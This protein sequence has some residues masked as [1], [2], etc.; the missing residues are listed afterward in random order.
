MVVFG[1]TVVVAPVLAVVAIQYLQVVVREPRVPGPGELASRLLLD[2]GDVS[3]SGSLPGG[4]SGPSAGAG[5]GGGAGAWSA[6]AVGATGGVGSAHS[7]SSSPSSP[8]V[9]TSIGGGGVSRRSMYWV[10]DRART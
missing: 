7:C 4:A 8:S 1:L 3:C 9:S 10:V 5:T 2:L 6:G